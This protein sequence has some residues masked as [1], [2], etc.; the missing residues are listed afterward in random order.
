[1][2]TMI[3]PDVQGE[4]SPEMKL[5]EWI[6][7]SGRGYLHLAWF[8]RLGVSPIYQNTFSSWLKRHHPTVYSEYENHDEV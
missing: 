7:E 2:M 8:K 3:D 1:M 6:Y 5:M 4:K